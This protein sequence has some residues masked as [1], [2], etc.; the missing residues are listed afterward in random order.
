MPQM[1]ELALHCFLPPSLC[2]SATLAT[3][4]LPDSQTLCRYQ[5]QRNSRGESGA[6]PVPVGEDQICRGKWWDGHISKGGLRILGA[7]CQDLTRLSD[8]QDGC[9]A[10]SSSHA[11]GML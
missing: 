1:S 8:A 7:L 11:Q 2:C 5:T 4:C 3:L 6:A 9:P 10:S